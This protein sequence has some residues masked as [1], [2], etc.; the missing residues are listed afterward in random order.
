LNLFKLKAE[1]MQESYDIPKLKMCPKL[2]P[3]CN[4]FEAAAYS[5]YV[6]SHTLPLG[7]HHRVA[8]VW[9]AFPFDAPTL[10]H[11]ELLTS[12]YVACELCL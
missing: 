3:K 2:P 5:G 8:R 7:T 11:L 10:I 6:A 1:G 12:Q 4:A 9:L